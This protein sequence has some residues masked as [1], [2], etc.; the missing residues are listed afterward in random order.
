MAMKTNIRKDGQA[1]VV[2]LEGHLDFETA[3]T[4]RESLIKLESQS[5]GNMIIFDMAELQFVGSSGIS[6]FVQALREFNGRSQVKPRYANVK[7]EFKKIISAFDE[8]NSFEFWETTER[9]LR[10]FEN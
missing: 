9:A 3:D 4:F 10:I 2:T 8:N 6:A 5:Q 1:V 7:S